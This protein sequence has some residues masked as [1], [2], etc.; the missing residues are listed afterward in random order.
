MPRLD[1]PV[2]NLRERA[3]GAKPRLAILEQAWRDQ[4]GGGAV[5]AL[6]GSLDVV[7][8][9]FA[10]ASPAALAPLGV[11]QLLVHGDADDIVPISQS[12]AYA[13]LDAAAELVELPG[14]DHFAVIEQANP[15]WAVVVDRLRTWLGAG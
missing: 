9:R 11:P 3:V 5:E 14:A 6:L 10:A 2:T 7:P 13:T 4:L 15:G 1:H 12:R 8:E